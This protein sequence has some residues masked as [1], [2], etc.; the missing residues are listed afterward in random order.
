MGIRKKASLAIMA[1]FTIAFSFSS[2]NSAQA[3]SYNLNYHSNPNA[4]NCSWV[5]QWKW[6]YGK[7]VRVKVKVCS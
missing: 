2:L 3:G 5:Y 7:K 4:A 1:L 6:V